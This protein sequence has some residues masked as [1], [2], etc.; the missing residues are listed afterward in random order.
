MQN[1]CHTPTLTGGTTSTYY[2]D[3]FHNDNAVSGLRV[4]ARGGHADAGGFA[5]FEYLYVSYG[6]SAS[7]ASCGSPLCEADEDWDTTPFLAV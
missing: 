4:P 6:V 3:G 1:L 5:G 2:A 7:S